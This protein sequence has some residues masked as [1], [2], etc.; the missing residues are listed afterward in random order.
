MGVIALE[1]LRVLSGGRHERS[2]RT[3]HPP[4]DVFEIAATL[5]VHDLEREKVSNILCR[6]PTSLIVFAIVEKKHSA[7]LEVHNHAASEIF[8]RRD[9][10]PRQSALCQCVSNADSGN[11]CVSDGEPLPSG[12][13]DS[14]NKILPRA[15]DAR[16]SQWRCEALVM[17]YLVDMAGKPIPIR[18][19]HFGRL[20]ASDEATRDPELLLNGYLDYNEPVFLMSTGMAWYVL[21]PKGAGKS[22]AFEH[23]RLKWAGRYDRFFVSWDLRGFPVADVTQIQT[24]QSMGSSRAQSAWEFLLLLRVF[25][26]LSADNGLE[27]PVEFTALRNELTK[28]GLLVDDWKLSVAKW[29]TSSVTFK[30]ALGFFG[31]DIANRTIG[32][33]EITAVLRAA[34]NRVS[35]TS[36]HII[37]IDGLDSFFLESDD[38]WSSLAGLVHAV[39]AVNRFLEQ[40]ELPVTVV[41]AVRTEAFEALESTD[42]NK[43]KSHCVYLDWSPSGVGAES[44]LW[45]LIDTKLRVSNPGLARFTEVY[46]GAPIGQGPYNRIPEYLLAYTRLLPRDMIALLTHLQ[47]AHPGSTPVTER[48]AVSAVRNYAEQYFVGEISNN[49]AGILPNRV[50]RQAKTRS[51]F[52]AVMSVK[53]AEFTLHEIQNEVEGHLSETETKLLL[54]QMFEVGAI[55]I[56]TKGE[57]RLDRID[58][59]YRKA[60]PTAFNAR[61][62]FLLHNALIVAWNKSR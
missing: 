25:Q 54:R 42:S 55:G 6:R 5:N 1:R 59:N 56:R 24:G 48:E 29:S 45:E 38:D 26:T 61:R 19:L 53:S 22:A 31:L 28:S 34:L 60:T 21:G 35:T 18:N 14:W 58:F 8:V 44:K 15:R 36:R 12:L 37:S 46:L 33:L 47:S 17:P 11:S 16:Q 52:E 32:P 13:S 9:V 3:S 30:V 23:L 40:V 50:G 4:K 41:A 57:N 7:V 43:L 10:F 49:L 2:G 27:A 39:E 20:D 51:F 62:L